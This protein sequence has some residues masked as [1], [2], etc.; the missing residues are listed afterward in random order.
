MIVV[1]FVVVIARPSPP[2][3]RSR[4][5]RHVQ[6][7]EYGTCLAITITATSLQ[8]PHHEWKDLQS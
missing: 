4:G 7:K 2:H 8:H 5:P 6:E 3:R 1:I